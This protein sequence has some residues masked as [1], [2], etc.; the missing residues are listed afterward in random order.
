[1]AAA[2]E[3]RRFAAAQRN[4][5]LTRTMSVWLLLLRRVDIEDPNPNS[6]ALNEH[7]ERVAVDDVSN[8]SMHYA[9]MRGHA[10]RCEGT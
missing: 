6:L 5:R 4:E 3:L 7:D 9:C 1:M 10:Y 8:V 2:L